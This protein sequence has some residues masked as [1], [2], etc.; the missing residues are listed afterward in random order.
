MIKLFVENL[1][2]T[3]N[4]NKFGEVCWKMY[5]ELRRRELHRV[6]RRAKRR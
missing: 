5:E 2:W 1:A 3:F 4:G 6:D